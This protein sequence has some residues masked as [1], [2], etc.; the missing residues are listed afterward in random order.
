MLTACC[1]MHRV[2]AHAQVF[3]SHSTPTT[4][5]GNLQTS[6]V[7]FA[8]TDKCLASIHIFYVDCVETNCTYHLVRTS[9]S[10][11]ISLS[12]QFSGQHTYSVC[13]L[14]WEL[15]AGKYMRAPS[16]ASLED[17]G[18]AK[19]K[20]G[21]KRKA[22]EGSAALQGFRKYTSPAGLQVSLTL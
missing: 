13:Q 19:G 6:I 5:Y 16:D 11:D 9:H 21:S 14:Q 8:S 12:S 22:G 7:F 1:T 18:R 20:K 17:K 2:I 10:L 4:A 3:R 15:V